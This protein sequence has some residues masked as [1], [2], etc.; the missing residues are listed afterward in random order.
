M[1]VFIVYFCFS[2]AEVEQQTE[3]E[4][5]PS[6][7]GDQ[8]QDDD[9]GIEQDKEEV[10][11]HDPLDAISVGH[12][13]LTEEE[14]VEVEVSP[15]MQDV[16]GH[17]KLHLP[18]FQE[19]EALAVLLVKLA[20]GDRHLIP[21]ELR[22]KIGIAS[23]QL[24]DHDRSARNFV[25]KYES[26]W[27][28]TLF[29]RCL[30]P[31][32]AQNSAAQK[33]KFGWQKFAQ[34][35]PIT[36]ESRLLYLVIQLLKSQPTVAVHSPSKTATNIRLKYQR[37][38]DRLFDDAILS[39]LN[40]PL[41]NLNNKSITNFIHKQEVRANL[42]ATTQPN[43]TTHRKV[44]SEEEVPEAAALAET[45]P[46]PE[47]DRQKYPV[48]PHESGKRRGEKR[49]LRLDEP[50]TSKQEPGTSSQSS[51]E[52]AQ[53]QSSMDVKPPLPRLVLPRQSFPFKASQAPILVVVPSQPK[54]P[55]VSLQPPSSNVPF[56]FRPAPP[57][58]SAKQARFLPDPS[59]RPCAACNIPKCGGLRKRYTPS[60][61]KTLGSTQ[62]IFTFCPTTNKS[63]TPGFSDRV[64]TDYDHFKRVVDEELERRR[65]K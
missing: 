58:P 32:S 23:T 37:I 8:E 24:A 20:E 45:L 48:I 57:P 3:E 61:E 40:L 44:L 38:C 35:A 28:Y 27:G 34:A 42:L 53:S 39:K 25:K 4:E 43:V 16:L 18:G 56:V 2:T 15:A 31:D 1:I 5:T 13:V 51:E 60:K 21:V 17:R 62:K 55:S 7:E 46:Q 64:Y 47:S 36:E 52:P 19:V 9:E 6:A 59:M 65:A 41:P 50:G 63:T 12:A 14:K 33:T 22:S 11:E 29:G 26:K 30:G 10:I 54:A 49:R